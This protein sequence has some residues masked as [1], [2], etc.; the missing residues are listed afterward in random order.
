M[1]LKRPNPLPEISPLLPPGMSR[2]YIYGALSAALVLSF[3][4][5]VLSFWAEYGAALNGLEERVRYEMPSFYDVSHMSFAPFPVAIAV[6]IAAAIANYKY[7]YNGSRS[8]YVMRR[9]KSPLEIHRRS[10]LLPLA[11]IV[12]LIVMWTVL[13]WVFY[14]IY[15]DYTP[16]RVLE[17]NQLEPYGEIWRSMIH[18]GN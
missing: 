8:I 1:N 10:L 7:F 17:P 3:L 13:F 14:R 9:I 18:V 15:M 12:C 6:C 4:W 5:A 11:T 16:L 2:T